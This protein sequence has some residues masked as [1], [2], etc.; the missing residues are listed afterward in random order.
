MPAFGESDKSPCRGCKHEKRDKNQFCECINC[1][2]RFGQPTKFLP[3]KRESKRYK[4]NCSPK[5]KLAENP[6]Q[7]P[8]GCDEKTVKADF[9][10]YHKNII[11][12]R[13]K[14]L[15]NHI[16]KGREFSEKQKEAFLYRPIGVG[17]GLNTADIDV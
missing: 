16:K 5:K 4:K 11:C 6:C 3:Q 17:W 10:L 15:K 8:H 12:G 7:W 13:Q 14:S 1:E 2:K 9:C